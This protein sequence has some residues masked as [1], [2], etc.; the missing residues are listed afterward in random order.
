MITIDHFGKK[1]I[2]NVFGEKVTRKLIQK[3]VAEINKLRN[4][5]AH[6]EPILDLNLS[7][8]YKKNY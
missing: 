7:L 3:D 1:N 6:H 5:I 2:H 8:V 4:R